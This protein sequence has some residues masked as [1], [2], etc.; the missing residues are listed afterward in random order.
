MVFGQPR[1]DDLM[2]FLLAQLGEDRLRSL[3]ALLQIDLSPSGTRPATI[4]R[5]IDPGMYILEPVA[6]AFEASFGMRPR[7]RMHRK[8]WVRLDHPDGP[9]DA[10]WLIYQNRN[11]ETVN[12]WY[13]GDQRG[14][15]Q[16]TQQ[17]ILDGLRDASLP[18]GAEVTGGAYDDDKRWI[19]VSI[20]GFRYDDDSNW[21]ELRAKLASAMQLFL[22]V[23][24]EV[25]N[26]SQP[27][28]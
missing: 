20:G 23:V 21:E 19:L 28:A 24:D 15:D 5:P 13:R 9:G 26:A 4:G 6:D 3:V 18:A 12:I 7:Y 22:E 17:R 1:Q 27:R 16:Q 14:I 25:S 2:A 11:A 8:G 10:E